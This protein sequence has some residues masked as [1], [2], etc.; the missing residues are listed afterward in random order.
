MA[1]LLGIADLGLLLSQLTC[2]YI[3]YRELWFKFSL[4]KRF[5]LSKLQLMTKVYTTLVSFLFL[6]S[7]TTEIQYIG[8]SGTPT[9]EIEVFTNPGSI[10]KSYKEIGKG[11]LR[12]GY[13]GPRGLEKIQQKV[14]EKAKQ[15]G[16]D[17]VLIQDYYIPNT[18][19]SLNS[20]FRTDSLGKSTITSGTTSVNQS[21]TTGLTILFLKYQ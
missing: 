3:S 2:S 15:K 18:G 10:G 13:L 6:F 19:A 4:S 7:C 20:V 9:T 5:S 11:F 12:Y 8:A 1:K 17:A 14:V 21:G 16:A